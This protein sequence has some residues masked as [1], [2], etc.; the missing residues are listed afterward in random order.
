TV[1]IPLLA[2]SSD[3]RGEGSFGTELAIAAPPSPSV[4]VGEPDGFYCNG[5]Q[6]ATCVGGVLTKN[7]G[8]PTGCLQGSQLGDDRCAGDPCRGMG[9]GTYCVPTEQTVYACVAGRTNERRSCPVGCAAADPGHDQC[10]SCAPGRILCDGACISASDT[11]NC[12]ACGNVC[13]D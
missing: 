12:G 9:D 6:V 13:H 3:P 5:D 1:A 4:C 7:I 2:C 11:N 10:L 8:C